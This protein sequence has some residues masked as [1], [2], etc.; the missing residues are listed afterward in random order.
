MAVR[1]V[2]AWT[3]NQLFETVPGFIEDNWPKNST[4]ASGGDP[5]PMRGEAT[6]IIAR[7]LL[8][9]EPGGMQAFEPT[10]A[11]PGHG[12]YLGTGC[13]AGDHSVWDGEPGQKHYPSNTPTTGAQELH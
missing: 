3:L 13:R 8:S 6:T 4:A 7:F 1:T 11:T 2:P 9:L 10:G 5:T 12:E